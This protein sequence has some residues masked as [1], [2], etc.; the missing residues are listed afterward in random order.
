MSRVL[1]CLSLTFA[2]AVF[3]L[4]GPTIETAARA[5]TAA[6]AY[7]GVERLTAPDFA[8]RLTGTPGFDAAARWAAEQFRVAGLEP[9]VEHPDFLQRFPVTLTRIDSALMEWVEEGS[10]SQELKRGTDYMPLLFS[11]SGEV[12]AEVVFV[13]YGITALD[14]GRDDY[15]GLDVRG[16]VVMTVRGAPQ[17]GRDWTAHD[18]HRA[19]SA[20]AKAHGATGFLF[21]ESAI[22]NPN[23]VPV[24]DLPMAGISAEFADRLLAPRKVA[25][26]ELRRVLSLGGVA[27]V[28][29]GRKVRLA[30]TARAPWQSEGANVIAVLPGRDPAHAGRYV[31]VGAHLDHCGDWPELLPGADD[32]ASGS[33]TV[34]EIA[35]AAA[36]LQPRPRRA[37]VF[38]LFGGEESGLLGSRRYAAGLPASIG[39]PVAAYNL[40]M[41]G[42]GNGAFVSGGMNFPELFAALE[43][44]RDRR[45]PGMGLKAGRSSGEPR[46]D[47][48][49]FQAAGIPA[50]SLFGSGGTHRGYHTGDDTLW[51]ITPK[52]MEAIGRVVLDAAVTLADAP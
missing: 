42:A 51:W 48:G 1:V 33:A 31:L 4:D 43:S 18:S 26:E 20:N 10:P 39:R 37:V 47:H 36:R 38:V 16:K 45:Q 52:T 41:V 35:R 2:S 29:T 44:A 25:L 40:D 49:P 6:G 9:P 22:A 21:A 34:L 15:A 5:V 3:A 12:T 19:R 24:A 11:G 13:G 7:A 14:M 17:D 23:G 46:A 28:A 27:S 32:N 8:G 30:V 50:V